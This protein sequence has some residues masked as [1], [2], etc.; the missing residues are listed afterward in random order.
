MLGRTR[1]TAEYPP[2]FPGLLAAATK[3]GAHSVESQRLFLSVVGAISVVLIGVLGRRV[4]GPT[5]GLVAAALASVYPMLFLSEATLMSEALFVL[6]VTATLLLAYR[7]IASPTPV[8]FG[9]LGIVLGLATL[10]RAE[11]VLLAVVLVVPLCW[12]LR[13]LDALRRLV[14]GAITLGIAVVVVAPWTIRNAVRLDAFVPVSTNAATLVDGANCDLVYRGHELGL[15]RATFA[16]ST[17]SPRGQA[18]ACF[19]GF[20][21]R[22]PNFQEAKA[23]RSHLHDGLAY[24]RHHIAA[25][26]KVMTVRVLRTWGVFAPRQQVDFES[27]EGRPRRW[28]MAGTILYWILAPF[29]VG[30]VVV[31]ARRRVPVWPLVSTAVVVVISAALTYGQQRFRVGAEPAVLVGAAVAFVEL[32]RAIRRPVLR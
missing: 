3:V 13:D 11:G 9:A 28:Q 16:S 12:R 18:E 25:L 2:L 15:W 20:D 17:A 1:A 14:L 23:A 27:L 26:P 22:D 29:A 24:A 7:A 4:A 6:L 30:G 21:I 5:A 8:R 10:T 31:L 32:V 19:E